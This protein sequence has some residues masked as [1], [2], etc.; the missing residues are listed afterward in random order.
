MRSFALARARAANYQGVLQEIAQLIGAAATA[1]LVAG[2]GGTCLYITIAPKP[3]QALYQ[4]IG[5]EDAQKLAN[6][7]GGMSVEIPRAV[8]LHIGQRNALIRADRAAGM[9]QSQLAL[10]YQ[11][12]QRSIRKI[13]NSTHNII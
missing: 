3:G 10:K 12:T 4:L 7:F 9:S 11:L 8:M 1:K 6:E 2:H 13:V 5:Q